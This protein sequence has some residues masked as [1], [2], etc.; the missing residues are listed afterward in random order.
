MVVTMRIGI[1]RIA[2][3]SQ[4]R[5][6]ISLSISNWRPARV[7]GTKWPTNP[8]A[9]KN[10]TTPVSMLPTVRRTPSMI[11]RITM[12]PTSSAS[13]G[14]SAMLSPISGKKRAV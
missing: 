1:P 10:T 11:R 7:P 5:Y 12:V 8:K 13:S 3:G 4:A 14:R 2:V 9:R 6:R